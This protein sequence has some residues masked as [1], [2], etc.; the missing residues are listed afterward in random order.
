MPLNLL[1]GRRALLPMFALAITCLHGQIAPR[2]FFT[3]LESG[4]QTGGEKG[5][6]AF[7][8]LYGKGFGAARGES[9]VTVGSGQVASYPGWS[10]SKIIV[11]L[12]SGVSTGPIQV[13]TGSGDSNTL[14]FTVRD[15]NIFFVATNGADRNSGSFDAPFAT[16]VKCKNTLSPGDICYARDGVVATAL[17]N[18]SAI[19][20]ITKGGQPG[21]PVAL[22]AYPNARVQ[23]LSTNAR[24]LIG[25]RIPN[26]GQTASY[27]VI[28]GLDISVPSDG[29]SLAGVGG[30]TGW[31]VIG[32]RISCPAGE[33]ATACFETSNAT[34]VQFLGNEVYRSGCYE[35]DI[36]CS[37]RNG[38]ATIT[39]QGTA[40]RGSGNLYPLMEGT[41]IFVGSQARTITSVN[42]TTA[43]L[44]APFDSDLV[45]PTNF[46]YRY[47]RASKL[48]HAVYF[49]T[50]SRSIEVG[51]N[52]LHDNKACRGIQFHSSPTAGALAAPSMPAVEAVPGGNLPA[53]TYTV[54]ITYMVRSDQFNPYN[55]RETTGSAAATISLPAGTLLK[56]HT[57]GVKM[58]ADGWSVYAGTP[59]S[60][61]TRQNAA[62]A[63]VD[64]AQ[65]W[66]EP[67]GGL[68]AGQALPTSNSTQQ[69]GFNMWDLTVHD[70]WIQDTVCD[71]INF[72]TVDPSKGPVRAYNNIIVRGGAGPDTP[73]DPANYA[74]IYVAGITNLGAD[75]QGDI[76]IY[77][78]TLYDCGGKGGQLAAAVMHSSTSPA[79]NIVLKDNII[80]SKS[81]ERYI[82]STLP[83]VIQGARNSFNGSPQS[84][85]GFSLLQD[86]DFSPIRFIDP[87][88]LDFHPATSNS[89]TG[90]GVST[91][92]GTDFDGFQRAAAP[93]AGALE[94]TP[95]EIYDT[96]GWKPSA[97]APGAQIYI[98]GNGIGPSDS[99]FNTIVDLILSAILGDT[100]VLFDG[101]AAPAI[102]VNES[103]LR[104][105]V[106]YEI[107]GR[108]QTT[109]Q[110]ERFGQI[111][112]TI[113][114]PV[115]A[116]APRIFTVPGSYSA[117]LVFN[118][119]AAPN[120][121][122]NPAAPGSII[123]F[124]VNGTGVTNP[125]SKT[126][127]IGADPLP[128]PAAGISVLI[129]GV[130]A[131][132]ILFAG[133]APG[134]AGTTQVVAR[135]PQNLPGGL[136]PLQVSVGNVLSQDG[137]FLYV[138][139]N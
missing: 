138:T 54:Q 67:E 21:R 112:Q 105:V 132:E 27:W 37:I 92:F 9:F 126:G 61:V 97:I 59:G 78:N 95:F 28:A 60:A 121:A 79:L 19:L 32:N 102:S 75:G 62:A 71:A 128:S 26:I 133:T 98:T 73:P 111:V 7:V 63:P 131:Q 38:P 110:V 11:Q 52:Y 24:P 77:N 135:L 123:S 122:G 101:V 86:S 85:N 76:E 43:V 57:P 41:R 47:P 16:L 45:D 25:I 93:T 8:T 13:H 96:A 6:G 36:P 1:G 74:C 91:P 66:T 53:R 4:P 94:T 83:T 69:N 106:P 68:T 23:I 18:Y 2:L 48:Y 116:A 104:V 44:D 129:G 139:Q 29:I 39:T 55:H 12:G 130:P 108:S 113:T 58:P 84:I 82:S 65:D 88:T 49:S 117:A 35:A 64:F 120:R 136:T 81:N 40:L 17:D 42:N 31:R 72:A 20:A 34:N 50:D 30:N 87:D 134:L 51:W 137:T 10:D 109:I 56:V 118:E 90:R 70:N 100:R 107:D 127:Q 3:D 15:G 103:R 119:N 80:A 89:V 124:F 115:T 14:P 46:T 22:V 125:A 114:M 33:G 99:F 5:N